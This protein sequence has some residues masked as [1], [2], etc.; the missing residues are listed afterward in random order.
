MHESRGSQ[1]LLSLSLAT[2]LASNIFL[3]TP[4]LLYVGNLDE[5]A[6]PFSIILSLYLRP[7]IFVIGTLGLVGIILPASIF[8]RYGTLLAVIS[9][10][11]WFQGYII[12]WDYGVLDGRAIDWQ[13]GMWRGWLDLAIWIV[14][15]M[16]AT[17]FY[18]RIWKTIV[19]AAIA[20]FFLQLTNS[21]INA[22]PHASQ[23]LAKSESKP[24]VGALQEI[25][26]FSASKNVL[27]L[28]LD[29]FQSDI[30]AKI[31]DPGEDGGRLAAKLKGFVFFKE[32]LGIFPYTHMTVPAILSGE[33]YRNHIPKDEFLK[34][35]LGGKTLLNVAHGAG[36]EVDLAAKP[37]LI[38]MYAKSKHTNSYTI[39]ADH[40][41]S[42]RD[43]GLDDALKLLDLSMFRFV[44][45]FLK[46]YVYN[47]QLWL[48][49]PLL[50]NSKYNSLEFFAHTA[51]LRR[52]KENMSADRSTPV[53]K[54][55]HLMLS[56]N[57]MVA[58]KNCK[59]AGRVLQTIRPT[60]MTQAKC[61]LGEVINLLERMKE[62]DIYDDA[63]IILMADHGAWVSPRGLMGQRQPDGVTDVRHFPTIVAQALPL[64]AIK[65]PAASG[66]IRVSTAPSWIVDTPATVASVL[67]F[68]ED[69]NGR[70]AFDLNPEETRERRHYFYRY[71][72]SDWK[73]ERLYLSP[74][75]E[76]VVKGSAFH[77]SDWYTGDRYL[78][79]GIV[80]RKEVS[81]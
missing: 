9:L 57:P 44:P 69:F 14:A 77:S 8:P 39:P 31:I 6:T 5:F 23:L 76:Y 66:N 71:Q 1:T 59:Y 35:A 75:Q 64:M 55:F 68:D 65:P 52:L 48:L 46:K 15:I 34:K 40:H 42:A 32:H 4:F 54:L 43:Y 73:T 81:K 24:S 27:H 70:S 18:R 13:I 26:R 22:A 79:N 63:L 49:Q 41:L 45:H 21:L 56:H 2:V 29:G 3:F 61:S 11:F 28:I 51:F 20:I 58:D 53:Y 60:V 10:L 38:N 72:R 80:E 37:V 36:Y 67:G 74:I 25:Y 50:S 33:I 12:V 62:L 78:P 30:F 16:T 19:L 47:D 7:A 17:Y